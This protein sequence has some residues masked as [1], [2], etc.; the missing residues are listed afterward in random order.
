MFSIHLYLNICGNFFENEVDGFLVVKTSVEV[1][2]K[3]S[4]IQRNK[5]SSNGLLNYQYVSTF[6]IVLYFYGFQTV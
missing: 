1:I 6:T 2:N 4:G 3:G 5:N